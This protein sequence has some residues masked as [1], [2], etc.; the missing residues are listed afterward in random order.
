[1][2]EIEHSQSWSSTQI[3]LIPVILKCGIA[4]SRKVKIFKINTDLHT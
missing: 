3:L 2:V 1:M 4:E